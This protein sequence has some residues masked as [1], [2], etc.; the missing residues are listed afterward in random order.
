MRVAA[1]FATPHPQVAVIEDD[2]QTAQSFRLSPE[3]LIDTVTRFRRQE[4]RSRRR[5]DPRARPRRRLAARPKIVVLAGLLLVTTMMAPRVKAAGVPAAIDSR[6]EFLRPL[7]G[8]T[9]SGVLRSPDGKH[10]STVLRTFEVLDGGHVIRATK[11]NRE[12][13]GQGEGFVYWDDIRKQV[14]L[15][16]IENSGVFLDARVTGEGNVVTIEGT[17]TWPAP[18]PRPDIKQSFEFRDTFE[19]TSESTLRDSWF[20]NAF[21]PWQPGHV[22]D[23]EAIQPAGDFGS[24]DPIEI[25]FAPSSTAGSDEERTLRSVVKVRDV[26]EAYATGGLYL[27]DQIGDREALFEAENLDLEKHPWISQPWRFCSIFSARGTSSP[28]FG[29]NWD[30]QNVG[31]VIV[32]RYHP[33]GGYASISLSRA[34]DLGFPINVRIDEIAASPMGRR[35]LL[36]PFYAYD[37]INDQ[38]LFAAIT[39]IAQVKVSHRKGKQ[40]VF[41]GYLVRK[42]LDHARTVDEAM[43]LV[44][45]FVPFDLDDSSLNAH[46]YVADAA[47]HSVVLEYTPGGWTRSFPDGSWQVTTNRV[48]HDVADADLRQQCWRYKAI[49]EDLEKK[50]GRLDG[51]ASGMQILKDVAQTGT[52]WSVVY[53][54]AKEEIDLAVYQDWHRVYRLHFP[55]LTGSRPTPVGAP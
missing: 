29:R 39:G 48:V 6:L 12:L 38:G 42:I 40:L 15:F 21:G 2:V 18:P 26:G 32:N 9:W 51:W 46:F 33:A 7:V 10:S 30:N 36:S 54:P 47:G 35:L 13:N 34:I 52:T 3:P 11:V 1:P 17:M 20:Q 27:I 45:G 49:S 23:Y 44:E 28:I 31:S 53:L 5:A 55:E 37:G 4:R 16:F 22:I 41:G 43:L 19:L 8:T 25:R 14:R 50:S 24:I